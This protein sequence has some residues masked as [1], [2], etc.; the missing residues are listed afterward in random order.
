M[1][2]DFRFAA[3]FAM[4]ALAGPGLAQVGA[5]PQMLITGA[6]IFDGVGPE[7]IEGQDVLV[8]D[9]MIAAV[10]RVCLLRRARWSSTRVAG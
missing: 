9:G 5:E 10:G 7:L 2:K 1:F 4:L 8:Q 3:A 6:R